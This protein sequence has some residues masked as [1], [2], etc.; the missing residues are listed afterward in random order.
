MSEQYLRRGDALFGD[1]VWEQINATVVEA[2]KSQLSGRRL[3]RTIG[4]YGLGVKALP[5]RDSPISG[6][7]VEGLTVESSCI[8]PVVMLRSEFSLSVREVAAFEQAGTPFDLNAVAE[9]A[10]A[11]ARQEEQVIYNGLTALNTVGRLDQAAAMER[12]G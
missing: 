1:R 6:K 12:R 9:A 3:V 4:P 2:G 10:I 7:P 5:F 11:A 8:I